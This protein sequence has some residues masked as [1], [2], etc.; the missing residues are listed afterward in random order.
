[1]VPKKNEIHTP[2][3]DRLSQTG[4]TFTNAYVHQA[5]CG[6]SRASIMTDFCTDRTKV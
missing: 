5:V 3:F 1:M 4:I 2:N 6:P